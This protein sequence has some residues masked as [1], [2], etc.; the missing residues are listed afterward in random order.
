[1]PSPLR[2]QALRIFRAAL[3]AADPAEAVLRHVRLNGETLLAARRRYRLSDFQ[4][5]YV[6][7]AG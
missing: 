4:N 2:R 5:I 3:R 6:V 1:M 7:G